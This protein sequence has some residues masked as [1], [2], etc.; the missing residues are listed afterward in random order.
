MWHAR[1]QLMASII[2][3]SVVDLP[4]PVGPVTSTSPCGSCTSCLAIGGRPELVERRDVI[5]DQAERQRRDA[6]L[7][8]RVAAEPSKVVPAEREVDFLHDPELLGEIPAQD[9][10]H[11]PLGGVHVEGRLVHR[12]ECPVDAE[13]GRAADRDQEIRRLAIPQLAEQVLDGLEV[14]FGHAVI[15]DRLPPHLDPRRGSS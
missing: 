1:S 14:R 9:R 2:E 5:G 4:E 8:E 10:Q 3:A 11:D 15:V 7:V 12:H 13:E 6:P